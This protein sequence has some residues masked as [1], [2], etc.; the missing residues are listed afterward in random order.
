MRFSV[1]GQKVENQAFRIIHQFLPAVIRWQEI[2]RHVSYAQVFSYHIDSKTTAW[3]FCTY[4]SSPSYRLRR[5]A[6]IDTSQIYDFLPNFRGTQKVYNKFETYRNLRAESTHHKL[7]FDALMTP[8]A[9]L[10]IERDLSEVW[11]ILKSDLR[12]AR[13]EIRRGLVFCCLD[14][15][16]VS[17]T[18]LSNIAVMQ[19]L[20]QKV[21]TLSH[22]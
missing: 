6:D 14:F 2:H 17:Y 4:P 15:V 11:Q 19:C 20:M 9:L 18:L 13:F 22:H 1:F 3:H 7:S 8:L 10:Q 21:V 5:T 16:L 12:S